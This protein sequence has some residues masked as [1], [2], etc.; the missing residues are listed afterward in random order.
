MTAKKIKL[1]PLTFVLNRRHK[2][3]Y[4]KN[5]EDFDALRVVGT[6]I[7]FCDPDFV[8]LLTTYCETKGY[9]VEVVLFDDLETAALTALQG[10]WPGEFGKLAKDGFWLACPKDD[11]HL[12]MMKSVRQSLVAFYAKHGMLVRYQIKRGARNVKVVFTTEVRADV[13]VTQDER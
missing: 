8:P 12:A 5:D 2:V 1:K 9:G 10:R 13:F 11:E 7:K 4:P 6:S 3:A